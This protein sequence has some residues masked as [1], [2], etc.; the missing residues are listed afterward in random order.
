[1]KTFAPTRRVMFVAA[2]A[3]AV[4]LGTATHSSATIVANFDG[5]NGT[6]D[7]DAYTGQAGDG[8]AGAWTQVGTSGSVVTTTPINGGTDPYLEAVTTP[9]SAHT[10]RR[11]YTSFE[12]VDPAAEHTIQWSWRF[13]GD[14]SEFASADDR[15]HFFGDSSEQNGSGGSNS[16]LIGVTANRTSG[17]FDNAQNGNFYFF[18]GNLGG[19]FDSDNM[20]NTNLALQD[21]TIYDFT[22]KVDPTTGTYDATVTDGVTT[23][24]ADGLGFRNG[25]T[26]V[27]DFV[28][29]GANSNLSSDDLTFALDNVAITGPP[30]PEPSTLVLVGLAGL[31]LTTRRRR[32]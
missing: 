32:R 11:Q 15:I 2:F 30:V 12:R 18:D 17:S 4:A 9:G 27:F 16:W 5:G 26:G 6:G 1:M 28:H 14:F 25:G 19:G 29:F 7:P 24:S 22:V 8:W 21:D 10:V 20:F 3:A 31:G 13:D 23:V